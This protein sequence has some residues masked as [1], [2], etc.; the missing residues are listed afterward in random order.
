[1]QKFIFYLLLFI[2]VSLFAKPSKAPAW[3]HD[4]KSMYPEKYFI[5]QRGR[6]DTEEESKTDAVA[7]IARYFKTQVNANL[8]TS[9][10]SIT[11]DDKIIEETKVVSNV[12]VM[13]QVELFLIE[14]TETYYN[15]KEKKW[16]CVA[17][18]NRENAWNL[19]ESQLKIAKSVFTNFYEK[20][21]SE[22][23]SFIQILLYQQT[24]QKGK[25]FLEKLEYGSLLNY[26]KSKEYEDVK[27]QISIVPIKIQECIGKT[28]IKL[29][30][31]G[32]YGDIFKNTVINI[33]SKMGFV[34]SKNGL[35]ILKVVVKPNSTGSNPLS[36]QP[37]ID[38]SITNKNAK[39]LYSFNH[40]V[41]ERTISYTLENAQ[42]KAYPIVA[43]NLSK[44]LKDTFKY[45]KEN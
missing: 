45:Y 39:T 5:V 44:E 30:I 31:S 36:I 14:F 33:F 34:V 42:K 41:Q 21:E 3:V 11:Q 15:K 4:Y 24:L 25:D 9:L 28:S 20:A 29:D 13:S 27:K 23:E 35:Y 18:I 12:E 43:E 19:Y 38:L 17:F 2:S 10:L 8:T 22:K 26:A 1:M 16:Y 7:Q 6:A 37:S 32:D 40:K